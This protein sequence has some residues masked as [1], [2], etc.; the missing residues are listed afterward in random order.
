[1]VVAVSLLENVVYDS[2]GCYA[3]LDD[4]ESVWIVDLARNRIRGKNSEQAT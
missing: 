1:M 2:L 3:G 4:G